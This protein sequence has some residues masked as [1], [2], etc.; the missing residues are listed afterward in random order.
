M[1]QRFKRFEDFYPHYLNE[2]KKAGTRRTHFLGTSVFIGLF[3]YAIISGW[4]WGI[5]LGAASAYG[6]AWVGHYFI[7]K[8]KPA[9]FKYPVWSLLGDFKLY[10]ELISGK[11]SFSSESHQPLS[12]EGDV[13]A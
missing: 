6:M 9:T 5:L 10:F 4:Y 3:L 1:E 12:E 8:N 13:S 7:E 11:E 2:H